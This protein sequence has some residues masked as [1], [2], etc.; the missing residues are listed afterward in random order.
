MPVTAKLP[1]VT[2]GMSA[3]CRRAASYRLRRSSTDWYAD[4]SL[5]LACAVRDSAVRDVARVNRILSAYFTA[6]QSL[7]ADKVTDPGASLGALGTAVREARGFDRAQVRAVEGLARFA[8]SRSTDG[9]RRAKLRDAIASQNENVQTVTS[10]LHDILDRDFIQLLENDIASQTSFYRA[11]LTEST[12]RDPLA[13]ILVRDAYDARAQTLA[14]Q[15]AAVRALSQALLTVGRG[16]QALYD[17]RDHL[18]GKALL[19][20]VVSN[21]RELD[22]AMARV[23]KAF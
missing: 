19:A 9:Y 3:S 4:D 11:A 15:S 1:D 14:E 6:L 12:S 20:L 21:A 10:A 17:A 7:A 2:E 5:R 18:G 22:D 8:Y 16:H 23:S 13:A